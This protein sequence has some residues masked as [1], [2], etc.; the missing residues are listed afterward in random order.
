MIRKADDNL[1]QELP[2]VKSWKEPTEHFFKERPVLALSSFDRALTDQAPKLQVQ[3]DLELGHTIPRE[4]E[5]VKEAVVEQKL[6]APKIYKPKPLG[7]KEEEA[8]PKG[9]SYMI[10]YRIGPG[11]RQVEVKYDTSLSSQFLSA[12]G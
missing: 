4:K 8:I 6:G 11:I 7:H 2:T 9:T 3:H 5:A 1:I 12:N 10:V